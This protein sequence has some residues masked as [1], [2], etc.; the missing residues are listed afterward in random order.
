MVSRVK[1]LRGPKPDG[2][3]TVWVGWFEKKMEDQELND[4]FQACGSITEI[5]SSERHVR[6]FFA[7]VQFDD[8]QSV[9]EAMKKAGQELAGVHVQMDFAFMDKVT[10]NARGDAEPPS[11]R[12]YRPKSVK[13]P[14]GHTLWIGDVSIEAT[15]EDIIDAFQS[16]G[17]IEMICL[18]VNQLRNGQFGHMK[19]FDS[20]AVDK[21]VE[22]AGTKIR[23]VPVRLDFAEDKPLAAYRVGKDRTLPESQKPGDCRT[24]WVGGLPGDANE[25]LIHSLFERCGEI[26]EV[27][28]D[29]SKRSGTL[30]CHVEY[31]E[32]ASVDRAMRL[33]GERL[34]CSKIRVD[35]AENRKHEPSSRRSGPSM[36]GSDGMHLPPMCPPGW[37][38][39]PHMPPGAMMHLPPMGMPGMMSR[40]PDGVDLPPGN[41]FGGRRPDGV[42]ELGPPPPPPP[43]AGYQNGY[44]DFAWDPRYMDFYR[45][46]AGGCFGGH[47]QYPGYDCSGQRVPYGSRSRSRSSGSYSY[48]SY[49]SYSCSRSRTPPRLDRPPSPANDASLLPDVR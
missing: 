9:D 11:S 26:K 22:L 29:R 42:D 30:F 32:S 25:E 40:P 19:F 48:Y 4:F 8:T 23:G 34:N 24:V 31:A 16:C 45:M 3:R 35:Y 38:P 10:T 49:S 28:L 36:H 39:P 12:R 37:M 46:H 20:D 6:G 15:E 27:R 7:H 47:S 17:K 33:S 41:F 13:P 5:R 43:P 2:C 18:Q 44:P 21:A 14:N 1:M